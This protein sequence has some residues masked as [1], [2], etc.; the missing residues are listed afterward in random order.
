[1][2]K[3]RTI[4]FTT[5]LGLIS[6]TSCQKVIHLDL[7]SSVPQLVIQ[8][9]I[10]DQAGPFEVVVSKTVDFDALNIYPPV[11]DATVSISDDAGNTEELSQA[12][13][14]TYITS[15][16]QGIPGRTY[17]LTVNVDGKTYT[18]SSTMKEATNI[19]SIYFKDSPFGGSKLVA[20]NFKNLPGTENYYRVI[21]FLNGIQATSFNVFSENASQ[22]DT[23]S[24]S[25]RPTDLTST[26]TTTTE[27]VKGDVIDVWLECLD[28]G[29]FNYFR[30][31]NSEG[32][33]NASPANPI[34]NISNG[35]LGYFNACSVR[36]GQIIYP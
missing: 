19:D 10:Y 13:D 17:T 25:F 3:Y 8:G 15:T 14:G 5:I 4:L 1:M 34:S 18:A 28:K 23:I 9:N 12:T 33:Q 11:T 30:T 32:G 20:L 29:V 16:T 35:A 21:H 27:L 24:Y 7:S 31:A 6:L 36:K 22:T 26:T 2:R